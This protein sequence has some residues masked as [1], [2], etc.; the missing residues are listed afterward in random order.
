MSLV[1]ASTRPTAQRRQLSPQA[2][3]I[4]V[5]TLLALAVG[6]YLLI[7]VQANPGFVVPLRAKKVLGMIVIGWA[8]GIATVAFQTVTNNRL[9]T[10]S[11]LGLDALYTFLQSML[12][13]A[14]GVSFIATVGP[15]PMFALNVG[16]M[17]AA[18]MG[19]TLVLFGRTHRSVHLIVLAGLVL[20]A[21]LRSGSSL[22]ARMLD[23]TAYLVLQGNLFATFSSV[24]TELLTGS[25]IIVALVSAWLIARRHRL[26]VLS[27]GR[28]Q[29]VSLGV[30]YTRETRLIMLAAT[31]LVCVSTALVGPIT[32]LGLIVAAV[33]Y[34]VAG[35]GRHAWTLPMAG[36]LGA[37]V[38]VGGQSVLEHVLGMGTVLGVVIE[39]VGGIAFIYLVIR[40]AST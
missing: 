14:L 20:G 26:D 18:A 25:T 33:A 13:F 28:D 16:L 34:E 22:I 2:R 10:P 38:I 3:L 12:V 4:V 24:N 11:I 19:L 27:L 31:L 21:V 36:L 37:L 32:F 5:G 6:A 39:F 30:N 29:S 8:T 23:P 9:L 35:S 17:L 15:Y 7:G 1:T 40:K